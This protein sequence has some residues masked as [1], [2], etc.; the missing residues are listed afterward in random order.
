M[1]HSAVFQ[2]FMDFLRHP[3]PLKQHGNHTVAERMEAII[4]LILIELPPVFLLGM[5]IG[6]LGQSG[7]VDI[8]NHALNKLP[9]NIPFPLLFV[10]GVTVVPLIEESIFRLPV[11]R[12]KQSYLLIS[13][14]ASLPY[15]ASISIQQS[16]EEGLT[17]YN[18][19]G[20]IVPLIMMVFIIAKK[21]WQW[22]LRFWANYFPV[23]FFA[24]T[25]LFGLVHIF[26]YPLT[27][28]HLLLAPLLAG[29]QIVVGL[30]CGYV[31]VRLG[32]WW[33]VILHGLHNFIFFLPMWFMEMG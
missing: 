12:P 31:R 13:L 6:F 22:T 24:A 26:N 17:L 9:E 27:P 16:G 11:Y 28:I 15:F 14:A 20:I 30:I 7:W 19:W 8:E 29:P 3:K 33:G 25:A 18:A 5:I 4:R 23:I 32:F 21:S 10:L 2:D 1:I